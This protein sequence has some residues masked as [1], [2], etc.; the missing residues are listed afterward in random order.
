RLLAE[1]LTRLL[2]FRL[3]LFIGCHTCA[4]LDRKSL[5]LLAFYRTAAWEREDAPPL[6]SHTHGAPIAFERGEE[7]ISQDILGRPAGMLTQERRI[8][9]GERRIDRAEALRVHAHIDGRM[10]EGEQD[11]ERL[12]NGVRRPRPDIIGGAWY[13]LIGDGDIGAHDIVHEEKIT[14]GRQVAHLQHR[15]RA[16]SLD[17]RNVLCEASNHKRGS[18]AWT[19]VIEWAHTHDGHPICGEVLIAEKILGGLCDGIRVHWQQRLTLANWVIFGP[20]H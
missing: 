14:L 3:R 7:R 10:R 2:W 20:H 8:R 18:L 13:P 5:L 17:A 15:L 11:I 16:A 1:F 6:A 4:P 12:F 9:I 19:E